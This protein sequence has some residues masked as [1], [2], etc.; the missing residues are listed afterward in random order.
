M[1]LVTHQR[2]RPLRYRF[3]SGGVL[4][5]ISRTDLGVD[6]DTTWGERAGGTCS[7]RRVS[8]VV[9]DELTPGAEHTCVPKGAW[10]LENTAIRKDARCTEIGLWWECLR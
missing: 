1:V 10:V 6:D 5:N 8:P 7:V 2:V 3:I 4:Y 9:D